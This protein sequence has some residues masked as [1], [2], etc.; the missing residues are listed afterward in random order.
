LTFVAGSAA[1]FDLSATLPDGVVRGGTF[2]V[3]PSG[4]ALPAGM[5]L[6][7]TGELSVGTAAPTEISGVIFTYVEPGT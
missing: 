2:G 3:S 7:A 5:V 6:A 1:T 4:V